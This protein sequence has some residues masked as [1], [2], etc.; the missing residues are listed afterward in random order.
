MESKSRFEMNMDYRGILTLPLP[1]AGP[2]GGEALLTRWI[3]G[4]SSGKSPTRVAMTV[5]LL[6]LCC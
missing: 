5:S 6:W 3:G 4:W 2:S 1:W